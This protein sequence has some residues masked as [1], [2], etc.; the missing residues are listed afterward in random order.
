MIRGEGEENY[1]LRIMNFEL[2]T[3]GYLKSSPVLG[4]LPG[5]LRGNLSLAFGIGFRKPVKP[6]NYA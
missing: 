2:R 3:E 6:A 4:E 5:G 1:E